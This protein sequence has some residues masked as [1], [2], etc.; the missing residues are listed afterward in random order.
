MTPP[1][2]HIGLHKTGTTWMQR[3]LFIDREIGFDMPWPRGR[4]RAILLFVNAPP[5]SFDPQ[6]TRQAFAEGMAECERQG[7]VP[8]ISHEGLSGRPIEGIYDGQAI[9][10]R[11]HSVFPE[12]RVLITIREQRS[13]MKSLYRQYIRQRGIGGPDHFFERSDYGETYYQLC[14]AHHLEY[15]HMIV[16]YQELFSPAQVLALPFEMLRNSPVEFS[17]RICEHAGLTLRKEPSMEHDN[18][19]MR[20]GALEAVRR[21]NRWLP[22]RFWN[23]RDAMEKWLIRR[24]KLLDR[25]F[26]GEKVEQRLDAFV[27]EYARDR[28]S[29][30]NAITSEL[31]GNDLKSHGYL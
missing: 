17:R 13:M 25:L 10:Q 20:G 27:E 26:N 9:A 22:A 1:L 14:R 5:F 2:I 3:R 19:G 24:G 15:H 8:V 12:G 28:F 7:L 11:L 30:S 6:T 29:Q 4:E 21:M 23:R 16:Y 31:T 18:V